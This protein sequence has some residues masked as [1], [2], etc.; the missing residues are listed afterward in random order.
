[1]PESVKLADLAR[2]AKDAYESAPSAQMVESMAKLGYQ[3]LKTIDHNGTTGFHAHV[4]INPADRTIIVA[5]RGTDTAN[6][7]DVAADEQ[8]HRYADLA[9]AGNGGLNGVVSSAVR[10]GV[11]AGIRAANAIETSATTGSL[12]LGGVVA[13]AINPRDSLHPQFADAIGSLKPIVDAH[14]GYR[15]VAT[16]HSLGGGLAQLQNVVYGA[17]A[18]TFDAPGAEGLAASEPF[19]RMA[20]QV[21][22]G[23]AQRTVREPVSNFAG[24]ATLVADET[25][26]GRHVGGLQAERIDTGARQGGRA[27]LLAAASD[28]AGGLAAAGVAGAAI[29]A[30]GHVDPLKR[31]GGGLGATHS[32]SAFVAALEGPQR[33]IGDRVMSDYVGLS[34]SERAARE[35]SAPLRSELADRER[36]DRVARGEQAGKEMDRKIAAINER[37]DRGERMLEKAMDH[38]DAN[39]NFVRAKLGYG[40]GGKDAVVL[41]ATPGERIKGTVV[42]G[43]GPEGYVIVKVAESK[44]APADEFRFVPLEA[45]DRIPPR[46]RPLADQAVEIKVMPDGLNATCV[47]AREAGRTLAKSGIGR[48]D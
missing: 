35:Q 20:E 36:A 11:N 23:Y 38:G 16:G 1:M 34:A 26:T 14:P 13:A 5:N 32:M 40:A 43:R 4:W 17:G 48:G 30:S 18:V 45:F 19:R 47:A 10:T 41:S 12:A 37:A 25:F 22:P 29:G 39:E 7:H 3:P 24:R 33:A 2:L 42:P 6:R 31:L 46:N 21:K 15:I 44:F 9:P 8:F 27:T 28:V